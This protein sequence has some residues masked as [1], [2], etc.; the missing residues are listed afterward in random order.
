MT[1]RDNVF[2]P[3]DVSLQRGGQ[4]RTRARCDWAQIENDD[5]PRIMHGHGGAI[6]MFKAACGASGRLPHNA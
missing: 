2:G 4:L 3:R 1:P 6:L 5:E